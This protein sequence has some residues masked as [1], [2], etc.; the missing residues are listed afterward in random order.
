M[1]N[2]KKRDGN[3]KSGI[4]IKAIDIVI[5]VLIILS[6]VGVYFRYNILDEL[7]SKR[8]IKDYYVSFEITDIKKS[9]T[10]YFNVGDKVVFSEDGNELGTLTTSSPPGC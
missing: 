8:N 7:T 9:T 2:N 6:L 5:I 3:V 10:S 4:K 1:N